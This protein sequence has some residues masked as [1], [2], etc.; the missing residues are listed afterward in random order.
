MRLKL[1]NLNVVIGPNASGKTNFLEAFKFLKKALATPMIPY[2][3]QLEWWGFKN[4]VWQGK[5]ELPVTIGLSLGVNGYEVSYEVTFVS[6]HGVLKIYREELKMQ[7]ILSFKKEGSL[8]TIMHDESFIRSKTNA[9][10]RILKSLG[11]QPFGIKRKFTLD[12]LF[13]QNIELRTETDSLL[14]IPASASY[15]YFDREKLAVAFNRVHHEPA[16]LWPHKD[17]YISISPI[18]KEVIKGSAHIGPLVSSLKQKLSNTI[19]RVLILRQIDFKLIRSP[20]PAKKTQ[21]LDEDGSNLVDLLYSWFLQK[22]GRLP[23]RLESAISAL[24]PKNRIAFDLTSDGRAFLKLYENGL[25]LQPPGISDGFYKTLVI[26]SAIESHPSLLLIDEVENSLF[27]KSLD[28]IIDE[29]RSS[30]VT[31]IIATHSPVVVDMVEIGELF[32]AEKG[33]DGTT[34][35]RIEKPSKV[36]AKLREL[37]LTQSDMWLYGRL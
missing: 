24:F 32:V 34:L 3:P 21:T 22:N 31:T 28:Y 18:L 9:I 15:S 7:G 30:G 29:L 11:T 1:G 5:E 4:I 8:L 2:A 12:D 17:L 10:N 16:L 27:A 35:S 6:E 19:S 33:D 37:G 36:R 26:I 13:E 20:R 14:T 23:E 25:E